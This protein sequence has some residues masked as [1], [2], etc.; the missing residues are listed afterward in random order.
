[1][2]FAKDDSVAQALMAQ[3]AAQGVGER[4]VKSWYNYD[5]GRKTV[6]MSTIQRAGCYDASEMDKMIAQSQARG[7]ASLGDAGIQLIGKLLR[8]MLTVDIRL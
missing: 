6:N 8:C 1:L 5:E 2:L 7:T 3:L 4:M